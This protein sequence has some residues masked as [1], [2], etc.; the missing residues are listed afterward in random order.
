MKEKQVKTT[1]IIYITL[2]AEIIIFAFIIFLIN[3]FSIPNQTLDETFFVVNSIMLFAIPVAVFVRKKMIETIKPD[4]T[5]D[6]RFVKIRTANLMLWTV[7]SAVAMFSLVSMLL[8]YHYAH[9]VLAAFCFAAL[10]ATRP[11]SN[12]FD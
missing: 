5:E 1:R 2:F 8:F 7:I 4:T 3:D 9:L 11:K 6:T 12:M 10:L